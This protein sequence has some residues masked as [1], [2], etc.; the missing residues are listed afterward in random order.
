MLF[1]QDAPLEL[2][3]R[4]TKTLLISIGIHLLLVA[5]IAFNPEFFT[6][7]PKRTIR[8]AGQDYDLSKTQ[9]TELLMPPDAQPPKP[10]APAEPPLVQ[11]PVPQQNLQPPP[12]AVQPPP[13]PPPPP[14]QQSPP[15]TISPE[16]VIAEGARP[17]AQP[18]PS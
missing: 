13:P 7:T 15:V 11:P 17:D 6:F 12:P 8:I 4:R 2:Q 10:Q 1:E 9:L 14:P 16:D 18:R 3:P 5:V